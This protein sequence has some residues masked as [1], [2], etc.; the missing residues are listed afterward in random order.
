MGV[1]LCIMGGVYLKITLRRDQLDSGTAVVLFT[2]R[3]CSL[4]V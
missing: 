4:Y 2:V 3:T 1:G